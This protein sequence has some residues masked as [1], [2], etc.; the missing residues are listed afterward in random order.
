MHTHDVRSRAG[1]ALALLGQDTPLSPY[2]LA[3]MFWF[4][5]MISYFVRMTS[6]V[7]STLN[8]RAIYYTVG[9][10][11]RKRPYLTGAQIGPS[12]TV[13]KGLFRL[14]FFRLSSPT[15]SASRKT[16]SKKFYTCFLN[17][18]HRSSHHKTPTHTPTHPYQVAHS[19]IIQ[20][21][22]WWLGY[23]WCRFSPQVSVAHS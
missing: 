11:S 9:F 17:P 12:Y 21:R 7:V 5:R 13:E 19:S 6:C 8:T 4:A 14:I 18:S 2:A 1:R 23:H 15:G 3:L 10:V 16:R 20:Q 22:R